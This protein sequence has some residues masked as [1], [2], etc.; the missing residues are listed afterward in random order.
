MREIRLSGSEGGGP[1]PIAS[2]YP[3][4]ILDLFE[5]PSGITGTIA[6]LAWNQSR[7]SYHSCNG[8]WCWFQWSD[9]RHY[10]H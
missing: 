9:R 4:L 8:C 10:S 6:T 2:P 5:V 1:N 3:Y 7:A